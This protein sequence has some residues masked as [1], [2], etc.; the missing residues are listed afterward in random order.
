M[1]DAARKI[2]SFYDGQ[3]L[4]NKGRDILPSQPKDTELYEFGD[5]FWSIY[6][7]FSGGQCRFSNG[8]Y[9][10]SKAV[11]TDW[12]EEMGLEGVEVRTLNDMFGQDHL[13]VYLDKDQ[14]RVAQAGNKQLSQMILQ[15]DSA[16]YSEALEVT[17]KKF[18]GYRED[19]INETISSLRD[20]CPDDIRPNR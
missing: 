3:W 6:T 4:K 9:D 11:L 13:Y 17:W 12:L 8:L 19:A 20:E 15:L 1:L 16:D 14:A 5:P 2:N 18:L 7:N 10:E